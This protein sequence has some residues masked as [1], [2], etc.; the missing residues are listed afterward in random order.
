MKSTIVIISQ[1][2]LATL[3]VAEGLR[4]CVGL[5]LCDG[6]AHAL[7]IDDGV[8]ALLKTEPERVAMPEYARHIETL[9]ELGHR[10]YVERESL[11]ER[12]IEPASCGAEIIPRANIAAL[13]LDSDA[14]IRF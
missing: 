8:Y 3:R 14:V 6:A 9:K 5:T 2:P 13:L 1:P 11:E 12:G 10:L 7:F 4:T